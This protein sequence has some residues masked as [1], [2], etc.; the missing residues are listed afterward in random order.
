MATTTK[1]ISVEEL[2]SP[3]P[4]IPP[5]A[6]NIFSPTGRETNEK[7]RTPTLKAFRGIWQAKVKPVNQNVIDLEQKREEEK[8]VFVSPKEEASPVSMS[9]QKAPSVFQI[10]LGNNTITYKICR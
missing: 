4:P 9:S 10:D 7:S 6:R 2:S 5:L 1:D 3:P 8:R